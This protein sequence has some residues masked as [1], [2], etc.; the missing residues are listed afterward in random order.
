M[1]QIDLDAD[2]TKILT[3][4][5]NINKQIMFRPG[6]MISTMSPSQKVMGRAKVGVEFD[7]LF[8]IDNLGQLLGAVNMFNA[9]SL[10]LNEGH[11]TITDG[12]RS[13]RYVYTEPENIAYTFDPVK[14]VPMTKSVTFRVNGDVI[15]DIQKAAGA[16]GVQEVAFIGDA[17]EV[18]AKVMN[19]AN[20]N[21]HNYVIKLGKSSADDFKVIIKVESLQKMFNL[22]YD[23]VIDLKK[24]Y[25]HFS[26][27]QI[28]YW[29]AAEAPE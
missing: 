16:L 18:A 14:E 10:N 25:L 8:A 21:S 11:L 13:V 20:P 3:N 7:R 5:A 2:T 4:F 9:P 27:D 17:G 6:N 26:N 28:D 24:N 22:D 19:A 12:K 1:S 23:V 15:K 29:L